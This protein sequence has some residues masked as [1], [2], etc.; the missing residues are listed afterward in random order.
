MS[1][2]KA[3]PPECTFDWVAFHKQLDIAMA[4]LIDDAGPDAPGAEYLPS[5][6]SLMKFAEYSNEKQQLQERSRQNA[7]V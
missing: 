1:I 3:C 7:N 2:A 6:V 5:Q 4:H